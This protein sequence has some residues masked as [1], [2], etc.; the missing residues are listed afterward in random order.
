[1]SGSIR[2]WKRDNRGVVAIEFAML[3]MPLFLLIL[4]IFELSMFFASGSVL[5]GASIEA[6]R[7]IRT[8]QV[9]ASTN[10]ES[11]FENELCDRV[12]SMLDC[13][14][15]QYEV[16]HVSDDTFLTAENTQP[17]FDN[18]G[19]L[20]PQPFDAGH[21]SD[22]VIVRTYYKWD[23]MVPFLAT[24]LTGDPSKDWATH[25]TTVVIKT[26]PYCASTN[27]NCAY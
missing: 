1:M 9:Q 20:I 19:N 21:S 24:M 5:E 13:G 12:G 3:A 26:E 25:M 22:V 15:L 10:P 7:I 27:G 16:I 23:F 2:R 11:E 4:G 17:Q 8:G 14:K 18:Q 6:A